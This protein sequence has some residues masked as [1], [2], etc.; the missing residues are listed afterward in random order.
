MNF[1]QEYNNTPYL[2]GDIS[3]D[4]TIRQLIGVA[5]TDDNVNVRQSAIK[6][7]GGFGGPLSFIYLRDVL[8]NDACDEVRAAAAESL[9]NVGTISAVRVLKKIINDPEEK[10]DLVRSS[11]VKAINELLRPYGSAE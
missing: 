8:L 6:A 4:V 2:F 3:P 5:S 7:L 9:V 1:G 10:S 11:S